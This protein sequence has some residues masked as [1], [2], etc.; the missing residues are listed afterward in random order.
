[1]KWTETQTDYLKKWYG[2]ETAEFIG[3]ALSRSTYS[4]YRKA[5]QL[6]LKSTLQRH[7][8]HAD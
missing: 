8:K 1:M 2:R 7:K 5:A 6:G 3:N 4:I